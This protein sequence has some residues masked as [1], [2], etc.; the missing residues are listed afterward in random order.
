MYVFPHA[1]GLDASPV[2]CHADHCLPYCIQQ[3]HG[4]QL[5]YKSKEG[6]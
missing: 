1:A 2:L 4:L 6:P 5:D 3:Q